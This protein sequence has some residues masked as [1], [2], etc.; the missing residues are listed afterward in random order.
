MDAAAPEFRPLDGIRVVEASHIV[1]GPACGMFLAGLGAEV[2]KVEPPGGEPTRRLQ[3]MG[4]SFFAAFN[5][6]KRSVELDLGADAGREALR[7]LLAGADVLVENFSGATAERMGL[8]GDRLRE[9]HPHLIVAACKGFLSGPYR[10]R[11]A[12]DEVIQMMTGLAYMT[13]PSGRP[14]RS[15]AS[16]VDILGGLFGAL[17]V[18]AALRERDASG[19]GREV[20]TGLFETGLLSVAQH[21]MTFALE[22]REAPPMP[23]RKFSWPVYDVF[24]TADD[25]QVFVGA[26]TDGQWN[27]LCA[28]LG[29]DSLLADP[30][31]Q[32]RAARI[33]ARP[34]TV[35]VIRDAVR[36]RPA[37]E[38]ADSLTAAGALCAIVARPGE[39]YADPHASGQLRPSRL[40]DGRE[41]RGPGMPI[42]IDGAPLRG[43]MDVAAPGADTRA[44]LAA[45]GL[46]G[47]GIRRASGEATREADAA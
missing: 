30:D 11:T 38:L 20:R 47:A 40:P 26:I 42:E 16:I 6:G 1:M 9:R 17:G 15:G 2:I 7:R 41:I 13:G 33:R 29:L 31:L 8:A 22:G 45:L 34:R 3:G 27:S 37:P 39:L 19:V 23:E 21:M 4:G 36:Q 35:P 28:A 14:L 5:R 24:E 10:D 32:S 18:V 46:D 43:P 44:V 12:A 25:R